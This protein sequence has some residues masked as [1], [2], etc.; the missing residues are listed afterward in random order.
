VR[1]FGTGGI[2]AVQKMAV[3]AIGH[4]FSYSISVNPEVKEKTMQ[5]QNFTLYDMIEQNTQRY[6]HRIAL[7]DDTN[8][9]TF[10]EF[11]HRVDALAAGLAQLSLNKGDCIC[12][13]AQNDTAY[14]ELYGACAKLGLIAYPINW[15]LSPE[16]IERVI[17]RANPRLMLVD[18]ASLDL[19][20][21]WPTTKSRIPYWYKLGA[22]A[23]GGFALLSSLYLTNLAHDAVAVAA[24]DPFAV[25]ST[26]AVDVI[27]RGAVLTHTNILVANLQSMACMGLGP[28]D[29]GLLFLP[30]FHVAALNAAFAVMHG[31]GTNVV[32]TRFDAQRAVQLI[33]AHNVTTITT[34]PPILSSVLDAAKEMGSRLPSL[35]H[36]SGLE[37][38]DTI[39]RLHRETSAQFWSGFGQTETSGFI[40]LQRAAENPGSA[41]R[42]TPF[43][44]VKLVDDYDREV[45][46]GT[47]GEI[48]VRGP[49]VFQ[50][51][52]KQPD[53]TAYTFRGGWHHTG[54]VGR[55][56]AAGFLYY[57]KR[58]AEKEL[59]KPGGEN[60]YP[61]EVEAVLMEIEGIMGAC[62]FGV[63]DAQWGEAIKAVVEIVPGACMTE[64]AVIAHVGER[65]AR[66]KR[67]KVV[68]FVE[69][70]H[71]NDDGMIDRETVK[72]Q[73]G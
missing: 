62:V 27:P 44:R 48:L 68:V 20:A 70:I 42:V 46:I 43:N 37:G 17:D 58:K 24:D 25:I 29:C 73:W 11:Q 61:A 33:D 53:E 50:G 10:G 55:F 45:P 18:E 13:L 54:D 71:K 41:G 49:M 3:V 19:V 72:S 21:D 69:S 65:I 40:T 64:E 1:E 57:V 2:E 12:I 16:E 26:A 51:Y 32:M 34:F 35:K 36:V 60:V 47:A 8:S 30:L 31:G 4:T 22:S 52:Y 56:D 66:F 67:P 63:P 39:A 28:A 7:V 15:R 6:P 14:V 9:Y 38:P 23:V 59:I 5:V